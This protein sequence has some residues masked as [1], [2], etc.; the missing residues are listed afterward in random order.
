MKEAKEKP[1]VTV[2][3]D[4]LLWK[5][6]DN[7]TRLNIN[8]ELSFDP[9][10]KLAGGDATSRAAR[11]MIEQAHK[12]VRNAMARHKLI[13]TSIGG[14]FVP[15]EVLKQPSLNPSYDIS[16][17]TADK[18][19]ISHIVKDLGEN[20]IYVKDGASVDDVRSQ[21]NPET[22]GMP[23]TRDALERHLNEAVEKAIAETHRSELPRS[24]RGSALS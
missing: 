1:I 12:V 16:F 19:V 2:K 20:H 15:S 23:T 5:N 18:D 6:P 7:E 4:A 17:G 21:G 3:Q 9:I 24:S 13:E 22:S 10:V 8:I 11:K 14:I